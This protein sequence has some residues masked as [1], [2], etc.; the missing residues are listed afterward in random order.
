MKAG[1][2][3]AGVHTL[4]VLAILLLVIAV[5]DGT[6]KWGISMV[7]MWTIE[8]WAMPLYALFGWDWTVQGFYL[9]SLFG[10]GLLYFLLFYMGTHFVLNSTYGSAS[11]S[12]GS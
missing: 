10:G 11:K 2:I 1:L 7:L 9:L 5:S 12:P 6:A 8:I 4:I 3:G